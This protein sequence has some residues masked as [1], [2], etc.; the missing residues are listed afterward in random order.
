MTILFLFFLFWGLL[1][2]VSGVCKWELGQFIGWV[3]FVIAIF[4]VAILGL[5]SIFSHN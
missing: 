1:V 5:I 3:I 2:F 4:A